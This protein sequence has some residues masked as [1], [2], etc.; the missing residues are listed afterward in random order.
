[1]CMTIP[2]GGPDQ[3]VEVSA[4]TREF[5]CDEGQLT[6]Q[7]AALNAFIGSLAISALGRM[8]PMLQ[9]I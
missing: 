3:L 2:A 5:V 7:I 1:M 8:E 6:L 4:R 9:K